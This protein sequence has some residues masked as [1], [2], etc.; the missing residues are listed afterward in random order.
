MY[1]TEISEVCGNGGDYLVLDNIVQYASEAMQTILLANVNHTR[2]DY[3]VQ[4]DQL[5]YFAQAYELHTERER[6]LGQ[7]KWAQEKSLILFP[8]ENARKR[9]VVTFV[10]KLDICR[11][12]NHLEQ[13]CRLLWM[14]S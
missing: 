6:T 7:E 3:L 11:D 12:H 14:K 1:L 2:S 8:I 10:T 5:A 9:E 4:G 13:I